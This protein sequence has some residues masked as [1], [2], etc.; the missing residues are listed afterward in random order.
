[1]CT[2]TNRRSNYQALSSCNNRR[3]TIVLGA[4]GLFVSLSHFAA[5]S[6]MA[7]GDTRPIPTIKWDTTLSSFQ[8]DN[9][10]LIGQRLTV[11]CPPT[12]RNQDFAGLFGTDAYPSDSSI[13]VAALHAGMITKQ[14]GIV[15]VQLNPGRTKYEGSARNG[16]ETADLSGTRR[17]ITFVGG[18]MSDE[19]NEIHLSQM[20]RV[21]WDTKF[22]STGFANRRLIGQ[23]F[24]FR[25]PPA[26]SNLR[27]RIVY[28]TDKYAFSSKICHAAL[29]AG[30]IST[31]GGIVTVEIGPGGKL[32][33]S[34]RNGVETRSKKGSDRSISFVDNPVK[35]KADRLAKEERPGKAT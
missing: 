20:P 23:R 11:K 33:G 5:G 15:T 32:V 19:T 13:C 16:V 10:R 22:T 35:E 27:P 34:R 1:M 14:G 29:H 3:R 2:K 21:D 8:F 18:P 6:A 24:T 26:P 9:D 7:E 30:R 28:G 17:S 4:I 25:V 12:P 31:A